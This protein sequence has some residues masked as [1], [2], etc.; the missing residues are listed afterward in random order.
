MLSELRVFINIF[1][2]NS[3]ENFHNNIY[4]IRIKINVYVILQLEIT[5]I[6]K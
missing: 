5:A 3:I 6:K 2:I 1:H 4:R